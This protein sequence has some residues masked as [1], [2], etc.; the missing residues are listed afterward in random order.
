M[1]TTQ[2]TPNYLDPRT[3]AQVRGLELQARLVVEGFLAGQHRSQQYGFAVEFAQHREYVPGDDI[4]HIDWKVWGRTE[5]YYLKQYELETNLVAWVLVDASQ[6]MAYRSGPVSKYDYACMAAASLA[7]LVVQQ[8]DSVGLAVFDA[9][10]R[11]FLRPASQATHLRECV[12]ALEGGTS[13]A[14]TRLGAV[15]HDVANRAAQRG[16]VM[17]FS[18]LFDDV[19][20]ILSGLQHLRYDRHEVVVFHVL[21]AAELDFPFEDPTLFRGLEVPAELLTDP[22]GLRQGYLRALHA[23]REELTRG[24]R[25]M[26]IDVVPLRTDQPLGTALAR[27][28]AHR[29]DRMKR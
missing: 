1:P 7:Y 15:L 4:K 27:Y 14:P 17:L 22:R 5:R 24:C 21:D 18:D 28:L 9:Q 20:A 8:T 29:L 26:N 10:V 12:R 25:A 3:L 2:A 16:L 23:F 13:A 19:P 6:S 11:R